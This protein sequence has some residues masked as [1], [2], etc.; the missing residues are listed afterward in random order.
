MLPYLTL[1]HALAAVFFCLF[2]LHFHQDGYYA[3]KLR[4]GRD[5]VNNYTASCMLREGMVGELYQPAAF[6]QAIDSRFG[7]NYPSQQWSYPP[8]FLPLLAPLCYVSYDTALWVYLATTLAFFLWA[9]RCYGV[10]WPLLLIASTGYFALLNIW[11]GHNG[12]LLGGLLLFALRSRVEKPWITAGCLALLWIKPPLGLFFPFLFAIEGRYRL[13]L[14]TLLAI[15]LWQGIC[16]LYF[17]FQPFLLYFQ[18]TAPQQAHILA[19]YVG[20]FLHMLV[21]PF[22]LLRETGLTSRQ[23]LP[24]QA[25]ISLVIFALTLRAFIINRLTPVHNDTLLLLAT[26]LVFPY[27]VGYD[28]VA[29]YTMLLCWANKPARQ[30][31]VTCFLLLF[32][33]LATASFLYAYLGGVKYSVVPCG[34]LLAFALIQGKDAQ[35]FYAPY[36][37]KGK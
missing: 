30:P 4:T 11:A 23:T 37:T 1:L 32:N 16:M 28:A 21:S 26:G 36:F 35:L 8:V 3:D 24:L 7:A 10:R 27:F 9:A 29:L 15:C 12:F 2:W 34:M 22:G 17:G 13:I 31:G 33:T 20:P 14:Q 5:F 18:V 25:F 6:Q 19:S